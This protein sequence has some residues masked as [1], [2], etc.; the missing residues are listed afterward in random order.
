MNSKKHYVDSGKSAM[1]GHKSSQNANKGRLSQSKKPMN[2]RP[3]GRTSDA[4]GC[5]SAGT[6]AS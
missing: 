6:N 3:A 5:K 2:D 1:F 4:A